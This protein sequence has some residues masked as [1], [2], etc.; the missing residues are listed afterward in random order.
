M[1][2]ANS[3]SVTRDLIKHLSVG[4]AGFAAIL[5]RATDAGVRFEKSETDRLE[6]MAS[7]IA[8]VVRRQRAA[9]EQGGF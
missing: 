9:R 4:W 5:A 6:K 2:H 3:E 1:D 7:G 8:D